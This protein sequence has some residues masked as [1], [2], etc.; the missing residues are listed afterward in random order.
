MIKLITELPIFK[1]VTNATIRLQSQKLIYGFDKPFLQFYQI[2][3][4]AIFSVFDNV[5]T[6]YVWNIDN[7]SEIIAFIKMSSSISIVFT[8][9]KT[10]NIL[11]RFIPCHIK[12]VDLMRK[13]N[14]SVF[15]KTNTDVPLKNVYLLQKK[16]FQ[17]QI[18]AFDIWYSDL[19]YRKK[20]DAFHLVAIQNDV[21]VVS[22]AM[23][24]AETD[25]A[26]LIGGV[27]TA[28][29]YR[30]QGLA[31]KCILSLTTLA[32]KENKKVYICPKNEES[33]H[34]YVS[35][36]FETVETFSMCNIIK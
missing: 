24:V 12:N 28:E 15:F 11:K 1:D 35:L 7:L 20:H 23:T 3:E 26:W 16:V 21:E 33:K 6:L 17:D 8:D 4:G 5:L 25:S 18:P 22:V 19:F 14:G 36:G 32:Q 2:D 13:N 29:E 9:Q 10:A 34:L 30:K 31:S 27:A